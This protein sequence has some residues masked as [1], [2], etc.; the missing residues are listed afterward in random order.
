MEQTTS[1]HQKYDP[2]IQGDPHL[3]NEDLIPT[4]IANRTWTW[5]SFSTLWMGMVHNVYNFTWLGGLILMGMSIGQAL[6]I[7]IVGNL[8]Q[9]L[10]IG[11]VGRVG[12]RH[13]IP[14]PVWARST[15][16]VYGA[17]IPALIRGIVAI[18]WF[19]VQ[20]YL[21]A[22][23]VNLLLSAVIEPWRNLNEIHFLGAS[24]SLWIAMIVYWSLNT[25]VVRRG[26]D[27]VKKFEHWAGPM[28]FVVLGVLVVWAISTANGI[29]T[30]FHEPSKYETNVSFVF[31]YFIPA[32]ALY[33]SG[34]WAS[35]V[36]NI[37]DITR[38][39]RSNREQ[40]WGTMIGLPFA[41]LVFYGMSALIVSASVVIYGKAIWNPADLLLEINNPFLSIF[42]GILLTIATISINIPANLISPAYDLVNL[43][44]KTFNF[45]RGSLVA[46]IISF[47]YMPWK[48]MENPTVLY[49]ILNNVGAMLGPITGILIADFFLIRKQRLDVPEL[50]L[51]NGRY[52]AHKGYNLVSLTIM[53]V[54]TAVVMTGQ[55][56]DSVSWL[57]EYAWFVGILLGFAGYWGAS[58]VIKQVK[59]GL[60]RDMEPSGTIGEELSNLSGRAD[61]QL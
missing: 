29:G 60:P 55:F 49:S 26:M 4:P 5:W 1:A 9:T 12:A 11:L 18:G 56:V 54:G 19:G 53:V 59:G 34:S 17:N 20:S 61:V 31:K 57:Y 7:A 37:P 43:F 48:L 10:L 3:T 52:R 24:G 16:G 58:A 47:I 13:G 27:T 44:P 21:G 36:L 51:A 40:F 15:F 2:V 23:A 8:I 50:Y 14:F 42:G 25:L 41:T 32:V 39:A 46:I 30:L 38:F 35:M 33:I 6:A 28:I 22:T 45:W